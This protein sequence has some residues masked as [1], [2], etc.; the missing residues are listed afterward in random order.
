MQTHNGTIFALIALLT[1]CLFPPLFH[2]ARDLPLTLIKALLLPAWT[3]TSPHH[4]QGQPQNTI[5][6]CGPPSTTTMSWTQKT[7]TLPSKSRGSYLITS[8]VVD[9]LPEIK[10][11]KVGLLNL[12]V[13]HTS[14]ALSL[15]ENFDQDVRSD[16]SDALDRVAPE[17]RKGTG[18]YRHDAEGADDM[19]VS[20]A[21]SSIGGLVERQKADEWWMPGTHQEQSNWR[22]GYGADQ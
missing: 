22:I 4:P 19:P 3:S 8:H 13:Q 6:N 5:C 15:N 10:D 11:Y 20:T 2:F 21:V 17:D 7:F 14:C 12:F 18:L 1:F 16:M 9:S